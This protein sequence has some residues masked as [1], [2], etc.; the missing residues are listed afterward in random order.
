MK[1]D[2]NAAWNDA[3]ALVRTNREVLAV[4]AGVFLLLPGLILAVLFA[5]EQ[6]EAMS[7]VQGMM[8]G[9]LDQ[10]TAVAPQGGTGTFLMTGLLVLFAQLVGYLALI[11]LMDGRRRPTVAEAIGIA[12]RCLPSLIGAALLFL[13][14]YFAASLVLR[15]VLG[16]IVA[17]AAATGSSTFATLV[18]LAGFVAVVGGFTYVMVRLSLTL[19][20][21]VLG[22]FRNPVKAYL[23]SWKLTRGNALRLFAFYL[24]LF[25]AYVVISAV[26]FAVFMGIG[27]LLPGTLGALL[28]G[29]VSGVIGAAAGVVLTALIAAIYR[30]LTLAPAPVANGVAE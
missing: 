11:A 14:G 21:F 12:F 30:Q 7:M 20:E 18:G 6:A 17:G 9:G 28:L 16:A 10:S 24:L 13:L 5:D 23:A 22:G 26:I 2:M 1:F 3:M 4:V 29:I 19:A 8:R 25:I 15:L 27:A